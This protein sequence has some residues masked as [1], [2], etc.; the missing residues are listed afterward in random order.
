LLPSP[1]DND[2]TAAPESIDGVAREQ[3]P[4]R[5]RTLRLEDGTLV[6]VSSVAARHRW[7]NEAAVIAVSTALSPLDRAVVLLQIAIARGLSSAVTTSPP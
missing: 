2:Q 7:Q 1:D 5:R 6:G 4:E 3:R